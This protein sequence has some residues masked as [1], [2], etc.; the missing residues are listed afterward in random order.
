MDELVRNGLR[1]RLLSSLSRADV[2][3]LQP[4]LVPVKLR[5]RQRLQS[6]NRTVKAAYFLD[7]GIASVVAVANGSRSQAEVAV[8]GCEGIVGLPIVLGARRS[9]CEVFIQVEG[10]GYCIPAEDLTNAMNQSP[11][12]R[13]RSCVT[14]T[15]SPCRRR[16]PHSPTLKGSS[17]SA[18]RRSCSACA[19][20]A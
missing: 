12:L 3:L 9:P 17:R 5:F 15:F 2:A 10:R 19:G 1:N 11:N 13:G 4:L 18:W 14:P 8:I 7:S 20:P 6:A 16:T